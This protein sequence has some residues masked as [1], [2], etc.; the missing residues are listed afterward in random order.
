MDITLP[1]GRYRGS[2]LFAGSSRA[3]SVDWD[4]QSTL[5]SQTF[6]P[7]SL[8]L[9]LDVGDDESIEYGRDA[10]VARSARGSSVISQRRGRQGSIL[11]VKSGRGGFDIDL[12]PEHRHDNGSF[13]L[14]D[15]FM[16]GTDLGLDMGDDFMGGDDL[17]VDLP[18]LERD[19]GDERARRECA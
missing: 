15:D 2:S 14:D 17:H 8:D 13:A 12:G 5:D 1:L 6:D 7:S 11:S 19:D 3:G 4:S 18:E 10:G 16:G 9:G